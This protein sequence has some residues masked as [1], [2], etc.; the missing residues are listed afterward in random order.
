M[1]YY[2]YPNGEVHNL[3]FAPGPESEGRKVSNAEGKRMRQEYT[4]AKLREMIPDGSTVYTILR[5]VSR[6]GMS[7]RISLAFICNGRIGTIDHLAGDALGYRVSNRGG[8]IVGGCGMD[9]GF[10]LVY[11]LSCAL[12]PDA[13]GYSIRHEWI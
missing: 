2:V 9:M 6:N 4:L 13:D 10:A 8:L 3:S 11:S 7:R 1:T 5:S 12:H